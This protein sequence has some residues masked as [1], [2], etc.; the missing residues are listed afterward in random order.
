M[1][2]NGVESKHLTPLKNPL[3]GFCGLGWA[4]GAASRWR[5]KSDR[6]SNCH[7]TNS[8]AWKSSAAASG[9]GMLTKKRG[10]CPWERITWTRS[11]YS[12]V[13]GLDGF[14]DFAGTRLC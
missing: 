2:D 12:A 14:D 5:R 6:P 4:A 8:P 10:A 1:E 7:W 9:M 13:D 11:T 3:Q